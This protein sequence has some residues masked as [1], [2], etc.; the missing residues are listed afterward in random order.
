M[1]LANTDAANIDVVHSY[2]GELECNWKVL[3]EN[4]CESYHLFKVHKTTLEPSTPTSSVEVMPS[5]VGYNH[6]TLDKKTDDEKVSVAKKT[7]NI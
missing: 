5:G 4:F 6:H 7:K 1:N 3:V 2:E